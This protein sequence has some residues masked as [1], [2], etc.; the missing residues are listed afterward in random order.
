MENKTIYYI[1]GGIAVL[2]IG[3]Y[4]YNKSKN[5]DLEDKNSEDAEIEKTLENEEIANKKAV[6]E[7]IAE[8][9]LASSD[10]FTAVKLNLPTSLTGI[11]TPV[12]PVTPSEPVQNTG[13]QGLTGSDRRD[14]RKET[15]ATCEEKYGKGRDYNQCKRRVKNGGVP[16][17][18]SFQEPVDSQFMFS[19][20]ENSLNLDL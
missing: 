1:I 20:F 11:S 18:G 6:N 4:F 10:K 5:T 3:Y 19:E 17:T 7:K 13:I 12:T 2:G 9:K 14:F 15:R 8:G 16:F